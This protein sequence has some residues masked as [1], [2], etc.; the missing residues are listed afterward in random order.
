[1]EKK[2]FEA[3]VGET[4]TEEEFEIIQV[5]S[6]WYPFSMQ[7]GGDEQTAKIYEHFGMLIIKD[8]LPRADK[9][10]E[11]GKR[12]KEAEREVDRI[13]DEMAGMSY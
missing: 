13:Q 4:L 6:Q 5:V 8:M 7:P 11:I 9:V 10:R 2:K 3:R 12:L 1:M